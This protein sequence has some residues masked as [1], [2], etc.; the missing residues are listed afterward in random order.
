MILRYLLIS[1]SVAVLSAADQVVSPFRQVSLPLLSTESV[2][3]FSG[4][5]DA[6]FA[7]IS[8]RPDRTGQEVAG[9]PRKPHFSIEIIG[10]KGNT[11]LTPR[12]GLYAGLV[13]MAGQRF[14]VDRR[15]FS[16]AAAREQVIYEAGIEKESK[17]VAVQAVS[18]AYDRGTWVRLLQDGSVQLHTV[19]TGLQRS[20]PDPLPPTSIAGLTPQ[21]RPATV[22]VTGLSRY[23][24]VDRA[25]GRVALIVGQD[26]HFSTISDPS[27]DSGLGKSKDYVAAMTAKHLSD[28]PSA[29]GRGAVTPLIIA[30]AASGGDGSI[31]CLMSPTHPTQPLV[32]QISDEG[33]VLHRYRFS[34][35]L[36]PG[37]KAPVPSM[38]AFGLNAIAIA[39]P[40]GDIFLYRP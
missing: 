11:R 14:A 15:L 17:P 7:L 29:V 13:P 30:S 25:L 32:L 35:P 19:S 26:T 27:V 10:A 38:V 37:K 36:R 18:S 9:T 22:L 24:V 8:K 40:D 39:F 5:S 12:E 16:L 1:L 21:I 2:V 33:R 20:Y 3:E 4:N 34:V 6:L 31:Y 23:A 28:G